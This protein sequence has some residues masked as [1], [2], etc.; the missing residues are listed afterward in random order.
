MTQPETI[1]QFGGG[2]FLRAFADV[3]VDEANRSGQ[4]VGK[5]VVIQSTPSGVAETINQ[6]GG[7]YHVVT[8]GIRDGRV[9]DTTQ[10]IESIS[11][12]FVAQTQWADVRNVAATEAM[13]FVIS[14]TTE[15][16]LALDA[17]DTHRRPA[18][19]C[20]CSFPAKLLDVLWHRWEEGFSQGLAILPCELLPKN[21]DRLRELVLEQARI[22][23]APPALVEWLREACVWLNSL[24]DRIVSG[25]PAAHPLSESDPLLTVA[26]P[27][28]LWAIEKDD[29][30]PPFEH[31]AILRVDDT[32]AYELRKVRILNGAH[33]ALVIKAMPLGIQTVREAIEHRDIERWLL[34]LLEE[35]IVPTIDARVPDARAF[36]RDTIDRFKNPYL[37]HRLSSIALNHAAKINTRLKP[38][39][40]EFVSTFGRRPRL[41]DALL[42]GA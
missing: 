27:F 39:R 36:V 33:T 41:L 12:A 16:G 35:E 40:D 29:R 17:N 11:R 28:A 32:A 34:Q 5:A 10:R 37:D 9:V 18:G 6:C 8:R 20:P 26:E 21:A 13:R 19:E 7:G 42:Q 23:R 3:F 30:A 15:A 22:W 25:K 24:V 1:L 4:E 2:N 14:N 38:T 31:P